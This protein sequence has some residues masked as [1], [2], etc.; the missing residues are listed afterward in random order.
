MQGFDARSDPDHEEHLTMIYFLY[1]ITACCG[2]AFLYAYGYNKGF[3]R[4]ALAIK[5]SSSAGF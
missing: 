3:S 1:L 2:A 5:K 4:C